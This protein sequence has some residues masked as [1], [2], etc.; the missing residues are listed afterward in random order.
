MQRFQST[1]DRAL[2]ILLCCLLTAGATYGLSKQQPKKYTATASLVFSE[3]ELAPQLAALQGAGGSENQQAQQGPDVKLLKLGDAAAWTARHLGH[4]LTVDRVMEDLRVG[5]QNEWGIVSVSA[6]STS[7]RLAA[8]IANTYCERLIYEQRSSYHRYDSSAL[9]LIRKQLAAL[10]RRQRTE[11]AGIA[12]QS[13]VQSLGVLSELQSGAV[14]LAQ[15][16]KLPRSPSSPRLVTNTIL[17]GVLGLVLGVGV[18]LLLG[19]LDDRVREPDDLSR[20]Y[21]ARLLGAVPQSKA[22]ARSVRRESRNRELLPPSDAETFRLIHAYLRYANVDR[23]LRTVLVVSATP[24]DGKTTV[25]RHLAA[26]AASVGSSVLLLEANL[27]RP[28]L[29]Q[30]LGLASWPGLSDV[31]MGSVSLSQATQPVALG[32][33]MLVAGV[34]PPR[35]PGE[36]IESEA[37]ATVLEQVTPSYDLVLIDT[38]PLAVASDAFPLLCKVD[39]VVVVGRMRYSRQAV[40]ERLRETLDAIRAPVLGVIANG[41]KASRHSPSSYASDHVKAAS[42]RP[43]A[44]SSRTIAHVPF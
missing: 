2:W 16:A 3:S 13:R 8:E 10:S 30:R 24:G 12:L 6:T 35:N 41:C 18:A 38:S 31:L 34:E 5:Q 36:L 22:L 20:I 29:A 42:E 19:R 23:E 28:V 43:S 37:M 9:A 27:R 11:A 7:A 14:Q 26:A 40:A 1:S 4:G 44:M 32:L 25:A 17:G 21:G 39:G 33:D 15:P